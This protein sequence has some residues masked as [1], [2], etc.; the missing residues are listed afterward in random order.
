MCTYGNRSVPRQGAQACPKAKWVGPAKS[1]S[2]EK[3]ISASYVPPTV[4]KRTVLY[5][6]ATVRQ[7]GAVVRKKVK[8]VA[9]PPLKRHKPN[10]VHPDVDPKLPPRLDRTRKLGHKLKPI[11]RAW[12]GSRGITKIKPGKKKTLVAH[13]QMLTKKKQPIKKMIWRIDGRAVKKTRGAKVIAN[14]KRLTMRASK[15]ASGTSIVTLIVTHKGKRQT[16]ATEIVQTRKPV[17]AAAREQTS[18]PSRKP[19]NHS[20]TCSPKPNPIR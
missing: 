3:L 11:A 6:Q 16:V 12:I 18:Q 5:F 19:P 1:T 8:V 15:N 14:G 20:A 10:T 13:V 2:K 17:V 9:E 4:H 7:G